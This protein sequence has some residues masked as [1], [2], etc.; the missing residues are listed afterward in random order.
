MRIV[1]ACNL[2]GTI[3]MRITALCNE[4]IDCGCFE[5]A[6]SIRITALWIE[7]IDCGCFGAAISMIDFDENFIDLNGFR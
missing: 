6:I 3:S 1:A 5:I 7:S 4:S 2:E